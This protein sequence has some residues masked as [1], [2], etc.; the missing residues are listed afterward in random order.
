MRE[1]LHQNEVG[2]SFGQS[3]YRTP[4][5]IDN[6]VHL[7]ISETGSVSL[8]RTFMMLVLL[9]MLVAFVGRKFWFSVCIS[10]HEVR[11]AISLPDVSE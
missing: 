8:F 9:A 4:E 7:P 2:A 6:G 1:L 5:R 11:G 10:A 3:E